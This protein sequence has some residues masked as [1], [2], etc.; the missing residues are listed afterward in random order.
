MAIVQHV[1]GNMRPLGR[2][3]DGGASYAQ[4]KKDEPDVVIKNENHH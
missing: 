3:W 4:L 2:Y 1:K